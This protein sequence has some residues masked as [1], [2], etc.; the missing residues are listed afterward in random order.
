MIKRLRDLLVDGVLLTLP[1][2]AAAYLLYKVISLPIRLLAPV[3]YL[4]PGVRWLGI[5]AVEIAA[6]AVL[7]VALEAI[8]QDL[9]DGGR[10]GTRVLGHEGH[11]A[12]RAAVCVEAG[13]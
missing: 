3:S 11:Q 8:L 13:R 5:A 12:M 10:A 6:V 4:L 7:L 9:A 2:G 1:L